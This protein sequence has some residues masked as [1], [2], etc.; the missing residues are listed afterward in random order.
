M[1][2]AEL[3]ERYISR[4]IVR[5]VLT[6]SVSKVG[7]SLHDVWPRDMERVVEEA[8]RGLRLFV[9]EE[10]LPELMLELAEL[11][12]EIQDEAQPR[13]TAQR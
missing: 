8:M 7:V 11:C 3:L 5:S 12:V 1:R 13:S 2:L 4:I 9:P 6:A 10:R